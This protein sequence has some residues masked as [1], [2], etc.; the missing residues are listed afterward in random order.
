MNAMTTLDIMAWAIHKGVQVS[1]EI[2][3]MVM[4]LMQKILSA[5]GMVVHTIKDLT[6]EFIRWVLIKLADSLYAMYRQAVKST[7]V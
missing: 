6:L 5:V 2:G 3:G 4:S 7:I 1:K